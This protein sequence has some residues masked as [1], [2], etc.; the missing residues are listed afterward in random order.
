MATNAELSQ[1]RKLFAE[2]DEDGSGLLDRDEVYELAEKLGATLSTAELDEAMSEM[3]E[4]GS[5][6]V[7][8]DEFAEWYG[9]AKE[10][11][12]SKWVDAL[13]D[14][15]G[16]YQKETEAFMASIS[17]V[18][19]RN[20]DGA[21]GNVDRLLGELPEEDGAALRAA[22]ENVF[23]PIFDTRS[24]T[25]ERRPYTQVTEAQ[26]EKVVR[27]ARDRAVSRME[28]V[29]TKYVLL[30]GLPADIKQ[31][32]VDG[33]IQNLKQRAKFT[34]WVCA[35][36]FPGPLA[37]LFLHA[38]CCCCRSCCL[39][40]RLF[41]RFFSQ[42]DDA[43]QGTKEVYLEFEKEPWAEQG[44][45]AIQKDLRVFGIS[46]SVQ[47]TSD[48]LLLSGAELTVA[49]VRT[50]LGGDIDPLEIRLSR[51]ETFARVLMPGPVEAVAVYRR[52]TRGQG[53]DEEELRQLFGQIDEDGSGFLD[54]E[55]V[56]TLSERLGAPLTKVK[57]D[58]A[59]ADMDEDGSG[60]VDFEE[61]TEWW[62]RVKDLIKSVAFCASSDLVVFAAEEGQAVPLG[63]FDEAARAYSDRMAGLLEQVRPLIKIARNIPPPERKKRVIDIGDAEIQEKSNI[64]LAA[65]VFQKFARVWLAKRRLQRMRQVSQQQPTRETETATQTTNA[66]L[67]TYSVLFPGAVSLLAR[68]CC[69]CR[70][71]GVS[72]NP[73]YAGPCGAL[74]CLVHTVCLRLCA[75]GCC[76]LAT[77]CCLCT[78]CYTCSSLPLAIIILMFTLYDQQDLI[79]AQLVRRA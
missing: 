64:P 40:Q 4:D 73:P 29:P 74:L 38:A 61:F 33:I 45:S 10:R 20:T 13:N 70:C 5:G 62:G 21:L 57:L 42:G 23:T 76:C 3:D 9:A 69:C 36:A 77:C 78:C 16:E 28:H 44:V 71:C 68:C 34:D 79:D 54:R 35:S 30:H 51:D 22:V 11:G 15:L 37:L 63:R 43:D 26:W 18:Q 55:E 58:A 46:G 47:Y 66:L 8:F 2:I 17:S 32:R 75:V 50:A 48:R 14:K 67:Q 6:E 39:T 19:D 25:A 72:Y 65:V 41:A 1:L 12:G 52:I 24:D 7:D 31:T 53:I 49:S 60:E 56:A 59:M 27:Q